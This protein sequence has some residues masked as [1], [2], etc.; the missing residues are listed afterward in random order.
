MDTFS[1]LIVDDMAEMAGL[2]EITIKKYGATPTVIA[3]TGNQALDLYSKAEYQIVFLDINLPDMLGVAVLDELKKLDPNVYVVMV[4][5][6]SSI[7]NIR[8]SVQHGA[9]GFIVKPYTPE[10]IKESVDKYFHSLA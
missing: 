10:K 4:S 6:H 8:D 9:K 1:A 5:A 3:Q 7:E 2:L